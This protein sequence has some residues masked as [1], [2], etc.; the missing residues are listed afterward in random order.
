MR[1]RTMLILFALSWS[2]A[3]MAQGSDE[4]VVEPDSA[5]ENADDKEKSGKKG[6]YLVLPVIITEPAIGEGL[7]LGFVVL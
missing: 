4:E 6:K 5:A 3:I 1:L 7:G 2:P